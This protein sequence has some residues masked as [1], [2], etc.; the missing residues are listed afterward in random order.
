MRKYVLGL[1]IEDVE[2]D[3]SII[4]HLHA[5]AKQL[6]LH[7]IYLYQEKEGFILEAERGCKPLWD[8]VP[9]GKQYKLRWTAGSGCT[10]R[11]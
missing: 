6:N 2:L 10:Q 1:G 9:F 8:S 4:I 11:L 5:S 3:S 7:A